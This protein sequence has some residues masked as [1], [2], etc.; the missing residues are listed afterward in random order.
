MRWKIEEYFKIL[1]SGCKAEESKLR[2]AEGVTKLLSIFCILAWRIYWMTMVCRDCPKVPAK[3]ALTEIEII[4]LDK[5]KP[6]KRKTKK[7]SN[8]IIKLVKLGGYLARGRDSPPGN[9][10]IWRGLRKLSEIQL[11]VEMGMEFV[12]N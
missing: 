1:K 4:I 6:S 5:L 10:V 3:V 9:K 2:S 8:Y 12:G 11:G 7:L